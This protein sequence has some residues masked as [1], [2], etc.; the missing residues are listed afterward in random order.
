MQ[1]FVAFHLRNIT[2]MK[3]DHVDLKIM[4][5]SKVHVTLQARAGWGSGVVWISK[6]LT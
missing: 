3:Q 1:R 4:V 2:D 6:F 5:I